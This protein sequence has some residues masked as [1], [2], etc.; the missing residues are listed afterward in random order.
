MLQRLAFPLAEAAFAF[1][2]KDIGDIDAGAPFDLGVAVME[3]PGQRAGQ[4]PAHGGL[5]GT[6]GTNE[7][8][9]VLAS[10]EGAIKKTAA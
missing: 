10:M 4:V 8:E 9:A 2:L 7:K 3:I 5:A 6:H 1:F